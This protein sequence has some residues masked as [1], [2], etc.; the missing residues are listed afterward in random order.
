MPTR[1]VRLPAIVGDFASVRVYRLLPPGVM[2]QHA[3]LFARE[4]FGLQDL[5]DGGRTFTVH[6]TSGYLFYADKTELW[7]NAGDQLLP[8]GEVEPRARRFIEQANKRIA[9]NPTLR[10]DSVISIFP[11]DLR[12]IRIAGVVPKGANQPDHW[13][14]EFGAY[15]P[16]DA[17]RA[18]RV[19]GAVV[20]VRI[21]RGGR[22]IGLTSRWRPIIGEL[23][24]TERYGERR[25]DAQYADGAGGIRPP[26]PA[27]R[28]RIT[29]VASGHTSGTDVEH[30]HDAPA[31]F[32]Y[33]LADANAPQT[34][35]APMLAQLDG[36]HGDLFPGSLHT[37]KISIL[38]RTVGARME[39]AARVDGG[40]G[41]R[42]LEYEWSAWTPGTYFTSGI[43]LLGTGPSVTVDAGAYQM[44]LGVRDRITGAVAIA[45]HAVFPKTE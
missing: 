9:V 32:V 26:A 10:R 19:E 18:A 15:L 3:R 41:S 29:T 17:R 1:E 45:E 36:E 2:H 20:D 37:L 40:S 13:Q 24:S 35:I 39:V 8:K 42:N 31:L 22:I 25:A 28:P 33:W 27:T 11:A 23:L 4:L 44:L 16:V 12:L 38:Q 34:F 43:S 14:C 7:M 21:G 5:N 6:P 30:Q